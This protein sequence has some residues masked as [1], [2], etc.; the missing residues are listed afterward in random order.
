[1]IMLALPPLTGGA[2]VVRASS[3]PGEFDA[4]DNECKGARL[5]RPNSRTRQPKLP[6]KV[7]AHSAPPQA[8][9]SVHTYSSRRR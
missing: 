7:T 9:F 2:S 6:L 1:M 5:P 4:D 8:V 3:G